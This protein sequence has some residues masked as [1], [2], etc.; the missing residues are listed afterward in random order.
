MS[1]TYEIIRHTLTTTFRI[2]GDE[3]TPES[4]LEELEIDSLALAE[5]A[6]ILEQKLGVKPHSEHTTRTS[7]LAEITQY[8]DEQLALRVAAR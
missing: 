1:D 3:V 6:L 7:R 4:T 8:I 5:F 2:P